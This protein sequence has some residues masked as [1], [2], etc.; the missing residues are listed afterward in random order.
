M[1]G[2]SI[3]VAVVY[4]APGR[5][6]DFLFTRVTVSYT[7]SLYV[8]PP[9]ENHG[10]HTSSFQ[11]LSRPLSSIREGQGDDLVEGGEFDLVVQRV[12]LDFMVQHCRT[13]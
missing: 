8:I 4:C 12:R 6:L 3:A 9:T 1:K 7:S 13:S 11:N 2:S 5:W 10:E